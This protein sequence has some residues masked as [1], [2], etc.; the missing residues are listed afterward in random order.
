MIS[1]SNIEQFARSVQNAY[2][3]LSRATA[4]K[5]AKLEYDLNE[6]ALS[7][8]AEW[9]GK[10]DPHKYRRK[11]SLKQ[12]FKIVRDGVDVEITYDAEFMNDYQHHQSNEIIFNNAFIEGYHGGSMGTDKYGDIATTPS[13]RKPFLK[14]THW[15][16]EA[17]RSP[18][19]QKKIEKKAEKLIKQ[20]E[21]EWRSVLYDQILTPIQKSFNKL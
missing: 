21:E 11:G 13:W 15:G 10:Y 5:P 3:M 2:N 19:P 1:V 18:S 7:A 12:A 14:Y 17:V 4:Q 9:Y 16:D 6:E 20:Y 8:I